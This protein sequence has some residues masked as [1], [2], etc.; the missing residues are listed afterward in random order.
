MCVLENVMEPL[1]NAQLRALAPDDLERLR[2]HLHP[3]TFALGDVLYGPGDPVR[4]VYWVETGLLSVVSSSP[5]GQ[6]VETMMV[7]QEGA[8]GLIEAC[9][10]GASFMTVLV[11]IEGR[12]WRAPASACRELADASPTFRELVWRHAASQLAEAGQSAVCQAR[13]PVDRRCARWLLESWD[14]AGV[15]DVVPLT[16]EYLAAMLG[17]QRTTV[18][19]VAVELQ[20]RGLIR[21]S[22]GRIEI[23]DPAGLEAAACDCRRAVKAFREGRAAE[24]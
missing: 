18:A 21:Y 5:E 4:S 24:L 12:G 10:R 23:L 15:G 6:S 14:R 22:R 19:P 11:Q 7:G 9:A 3:V 20:R 17:V 8:A 13:H 1:Q 16:Q 2:P